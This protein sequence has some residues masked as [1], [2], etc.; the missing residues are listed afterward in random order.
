M[1]L[2][3]TPRMTLQA[4]GQ[5]FVATGDYEGFMALSTPR[6]YDFL[7]YG[8][9]PATIQR[10]DDLYTADADGP[11]PADPIRFLNPRLPNALVPE[12][13]RAALGIPSGLDPVPSLEPG[14]GGLGPRSRPSTARAT[15]S[16]SSRTPCAT[17]S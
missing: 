16:A 15:S 4:Y 9:G 6:T 12:Q 17:C 7:R 14:Q 13:R 8:E 2:A 3:I 11:G 1:D 10:N 5:P